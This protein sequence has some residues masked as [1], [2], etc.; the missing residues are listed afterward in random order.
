MATADISEMIARECIA[1]RVR[2]LNRVVTK[3]YDECLR[4]HGLRTAQQNILVATS[5]MKSA[6]PSELERRLNLDKSTVSRNV[7]RMRRRGWVEFVSGED[8]RSHHVHVTAEGMKLLRKSLV[9]WK[10]AQK[11]TAAMLG[12]KGTTTLFRLEAARDANRV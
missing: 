4:P 1:M 8:G 3:I 12:E 6:T 2:L 5:L 7:E 9:A 10:R 11:K